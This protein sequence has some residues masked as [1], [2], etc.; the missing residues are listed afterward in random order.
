ME[1][2]NVKIKQLESY[3]ELYDSNTITLVK[4]EDIAEIQQ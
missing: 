3:Q 4:S 2:I 1:S